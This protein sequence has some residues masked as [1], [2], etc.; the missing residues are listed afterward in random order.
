MASTRRSEEEIKAMMPNKTIPP[1]G[2]ATSRPVWQ[3][4]KK[5]RVLL[6]ENAASIPSRLGD[7]DL[8]H[9]A[10]VV[11]ANRYTNL[12]ATNHVYVIPQDPLPPVYTVGMSY[13][14]RE[15][16]KR[17]HDQRVIDVYTHKA[18][19][20]ILMQM[21]LEVVHADYKTAFFTEE[22]R[23]RCTFAQ[24]DD[25]MEDKFNKKTSQELAENE[26]KMNQPWSAIVPIESLFRHSD[27]CIRFDP[28]IPE[29]KVVRNTVDIICVNDGFDLAFN[30]W[31]AKRP[32]DKTWAALKDHF[33]DADKA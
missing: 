17:D 30:D 16:L 26:T 19:E 9:A 10:I 12:S 21:Y 1:I 11:G 25:Y 31:N 33:G 28:T 4:I 32:A 5:A 6:A 20:K 27:A 14:Q 8:G 7:I 15:E 18:V 22:L 3:A 2:S 23:Y 13:H 29:D 24:L